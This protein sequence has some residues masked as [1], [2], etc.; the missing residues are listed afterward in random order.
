[1]N[2][3]TRIHSETGAAIGH[4]EFGRSSPLPRWTIREQRVGICVHAGI[5]AKEVVDVGDEGKSG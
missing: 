4:D 2:A 3:Q 1:M 5:L